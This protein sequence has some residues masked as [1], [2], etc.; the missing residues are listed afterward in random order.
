MSVRDVYSRG[1]QRT[2]G[3]PCSAKRRQAVTE[4]HAKHAG[5]VLW[6]VSRKVLLNCACRIVA[7]ECRVGS[8]EPAAGDGDGEE[9][10]KTPAVKVSPSKNVLADHHE[11]ADMGRASIEHSITYRRLGP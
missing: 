3:A 11:L 8:A 6:P 7:V 2:S 1:E 10:E 4:Y 9:D 5:V